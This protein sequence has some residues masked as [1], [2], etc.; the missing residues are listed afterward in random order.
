MFLLVNGLEINELIR[1][2]FEYLV[3]VIFFFLNNC[4]VFF[5]NLIRD[6]LKKRCNNRIKG[7]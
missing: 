4:W 6:K 7:N 1:C 2:K 3:V 5:F